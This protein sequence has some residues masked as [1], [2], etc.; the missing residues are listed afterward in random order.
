MRHAGI[1]DQDGD[2][3]ESLL[4]GVESGCHRGA[5]A[6]IGLD[7]KRAAAGFFNARFEVREPVGAAR[8]QHH[9][10]AVLGEALGKAHA[11]PA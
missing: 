8:H 7:R 5:V 6:H 9:H 11:E 3:A 4:R 1:V 2:G 10:R